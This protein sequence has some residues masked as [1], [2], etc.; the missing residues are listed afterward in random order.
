VALRTHFETDRLILRPFEDT[1]IATAFQWMS[2]PVVMRF[3]P[4]GADTSIEMTRER[5]GRYRAHHA[6]HGFAKWLVI[7]RESGEPIG[8]A[9]L[10]TMPELGWI[11]LGYRLARHAWGRGYAT[12]AAAAWV[13]FANDARLC[14]AAA[15]ERAAM[16]LGAFAHEDNHASLRVLR[17]LQF[18]E[19]RRDLVMGIPA[20]VFELSA[21]GVVRPVQ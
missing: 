11:D 2:D 12:E 15:P 7:E 18:H 17:K 5:I 1:D 14:A 6:A 4:F 21:G 13:V 20:I 9:G 16:P 19:R 8:D 10:M 3:M